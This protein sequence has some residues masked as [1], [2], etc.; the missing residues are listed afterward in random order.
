[1]IKP[2]QRDK[3][4][5]LQR[6]RILDLCEAT[7]VSPYTDKAHKFVAID[8]PSW[9]NMVPITDND[10]VV[11]IRQYRHGSRSVTLEIPG[12]MVDVGEEPALAA[13]REC[14]EETGYVATTLHSLGELNP[15]PALFDNSLHTFFGRVAEGSPID[16]DSETE[17][18]AV[19]LIPI[20]RLKTLLLDGTID[21]ALVCATLWRFLDGLREGHAWSEAQP[22][23]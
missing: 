9:V 8:C 18:T 14:Q 7:D 6:T 19:E 4:E 3:I 13:M 20:E 23:G 21:H 2:W 1:M 12:G 10:E 16:H 11:M 22:M 5:L 17:K 15:N